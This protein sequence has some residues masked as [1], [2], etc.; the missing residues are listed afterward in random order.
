MQ[1]IIKG[2][3]HLTDID[4]GTIDKMEYAALLHRRHSRIEFK[5]LEV[6]AKSVTIQAAQG[7]SPA[8]NQATSK[9]L[10]EIVHETFDRFFPGKKV[11]VRPIP[12]TAS[13]AELVTVKWI[14]E[15]MT[16]T[17]TTLKQLVDDT[18]LGKSN[19]STVI[20][21]NA[22]LSHVMKVVFYLYFRVKELEAPAE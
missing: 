20:N 1:N 3:A 19:L 4:Q 12:F 15:R 8:D 14:Q 18:G 13:P 10:V 9:R 7:K 11:I 5:I 16:S 17:G 2:L 6:T 22:E 21:G